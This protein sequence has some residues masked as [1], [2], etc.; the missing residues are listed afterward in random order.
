VKRS[1]RLAI[2]GVVGLAALAPSPA[3]ALPANFADST[4]FSG[5]SSPT[6]VAFAPDGRIFVGEQGGV[7][8]LYD[9]PNDTTA[10]S[11]ADLRT[12]VHGYWDRGLESI[13]LDP[14]FP[15]RPYLYA[16]YTYDAPIGADAPSWGT[17]GE[18][19][20]GCPSP[21]GATAAGCVVSGRLS[22]LTVANNGSGNTIS[23]EKVLI[24]DWC[25]QF[26]SHSVGDIGFGADG[27][28]YMSAG[29]GASFGHVDY[30]QSG[31]PLNPCGDPPSGVGGTQTAASGEGGALRSQDIRSGGD[32]LGLDGTVI[33]VDP[34]SGRPVPDIGAG[35]ST[36]QL[37][38]ARVVAFGFRNPFR[39]AIRP[40][41]DPPE[42]WVG[43]VG[44]NSW[45]E[46]D[47]V[48]TE[49]GVAGT[50][51]NNFGWPCVEGASDRPY[52]SVGFCQSLYAS[53]GPDKPPYFSFQHGVAVDPTETSLSPRA[54][55]INAGSAISGLAFY[56]DGSGDFG[57]PV[58]YD[59]SLFFAD[60]ARGCIWVMKAGSDG[61]PD[62]SK[63]SV[64]NGVRGPVDLE[65]APDG[66]LYY[67]SIS[68]GEVHRISYESANHAPIARATATPDHG[69]APLQVDLDASGSSDPDPGEQLSYAW[70]LDGDGAFDDSAAVAPTVTYPSEGV[71][72]PQVRVTDGA[73]AFSK[74]AAM[75]DVGAPPQPSIDLPAAGATFD[76]NTAINFSGSASDA[77]DGSIPASGLHWKAVL[78]H[79][80]SGG[81]CH[82]HH[83]QDFDGVAG[84]QL[85][86]PAHER[87]YY[88]TLTLTAIDSDGLQASVSRD[89]YPT[90]NVPPV[91]RVSA[92]P[93]HG[94]APLRV[95]L[96]AG[97]ST[98]ANPGDVLS[99][100]WDLDDDGEFDDSTEV[101]PGRTFVADGTYT[102]EVLVSDQDGASSSAE[103]TVHVDPESNQP[104]VP[105][106]D[107][108]ASGTS[109]TAG[110]R[111]PFS[112]GADDPEDGML[113]PSA[114]GWR[115]IVDCS[116]EGCVEKE[117][118]EG[119]SSGTF[120]A[121]NRVDPY[122]LRLQLIATDSEGKTASTE[123]TLEP[124]VVRLTVDSRR[125]GARVSIA[126]AK[127][128]VPM[129][130]TILKGAD[131]RVATPKRQHVKG[132]GAKA[133]IKWRRWSDGRGRVHIV[134]LDSDTTLRAGYRIVRPHKGRRP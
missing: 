24:N 90:L 126:N 117:L 12:E 48:E 26:P 125:D 5:L 62:P 21:P 46:I 22:R 88:L 63:I 47:R 19:G 67:V 64:F 133:R 104:P 73:G 4:V 49:A 107:F 66:S 75:V 11:F 44:W 115:L 109:F 69:A 31:I 29:D 120:I 111:I 77:K 25:Q 134:S 52:S 37:N 57:F 20:D 70:D 98:D 82:Q 3:Q 71:Y 15:S 10:T 43:D 1:W 50:T 100:A 8:K 28:L 129:S 103:V 84:G 51:N 122:E 86:M 13:V 41:T 127:G 130:R 97:G 61:E 112:G 94:S 53:G 6:T 35:A 65:V 54:C 123:V 59:G 116:G 91:A 79:C 99:Y 121:P 95:Q 131:V 124:S 74:A 68:G 2:A 55:A 101:S 27:N 132:H 30:G 16:S 105:E 93:D 42:I 9:G 81:G 38:A 72:R 106:I 80:V 23:N 17:P 78:N 102:P 33:R 14:Q 45:E 56:D 92:T 7:I 108:P 85:D 18:D 113:P 89:V 36:S 96:D 76:A 58:A 87:P 114:L 128:K 40:G 83:I 34:D 118:S 60:Y 119:T 39:F 32:P 110:E